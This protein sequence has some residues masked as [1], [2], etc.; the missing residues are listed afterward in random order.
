MAEERHNKIYKV[1]PGNFSIKMLYNMFIDFLQDGDDGW[2]LVRNEPW[3]YGAVLKVPNWKDGEYGYLGMMYGEIKGTG[4]NHSYSINSASS[5]GQWVTQVNTLRKQVAHPVMNLNLTDGYSFSKNRISQKNT[6][7]WKSTT[8]KRYDF[9]YGSGKLI[10]DLKAGDTFITITTESD[11]LDGI[12]YKGTYISIAGK[13]VVVTQNTSTYPYW[14]EVERKDENGDPILDDDG[15]PVIDTK[16]ENYIDI[17]FSP[18]FEKD[19]KKGTKV[20]LPASNKKNI[21]ISKEIQTS[22]PGYYYIRE[23]EHFYSDADVIWFNMFKQYESDFDWNELMENTRK[24][25]CAKRLGWSWYTS[26]YPSWS[27]EPPVYPGEGCPVI[28]SSPDKFG[29][30]PYKDESEEE[31]N[32][33]FREPDEASGF[34]YFDELPKDIPLMW[35]Y[36]FGPNDDISE[37][38]LYGIDIEFTIGE[39]TFE[40]CLEREYIKKIHIVDVEA[41]HWLELHTPTLV[42]RNNLYYEC[43][44][45]YGEH[46]ETMVQLL[47][48]YDK[49]HKLQHG[50]ESCYRAIQPFNGY[51]CHYSIYYY[52]TKTSCNYYVCDQNC[53]LPI[54][55]NKPKKLSSAV[56]DGELTLIRLADAKI[57]DISVF[58]AS[59]ING[60][61]YYTQNNTYYYFWDFKVY[62]TSGKT[63][64]EIVGNN[65]YLSPRVYAFKP[66]PFTPTGKLNIPDCVY[67]YM[68]KTKHNANLAVNYR[69]WWDMAQVGFFEPFAS[70]YEYQFPAMVMSSNIGVRPCS[71]LV[72]YNSNYPSCYEHMQFD[73]TQGNKSWGHA[74][75]G[76]SAT[77]WDGTQTFADNHACSQTQAMTPSGRWES[78]FNYGIRSKSYYSYYWGKFAHGFREPEYIDSKYFITTTMTP[79][80]EE[81][82]NVIPYGLESCNGYNFDISTLEYDIALQ[83]KQSCYLLPFYLGENT[84]HGYKQNMLGAVPSMYMVSRPVTR[85]GLYKNPTKE[86]DLFVIM[87]NC[88][89]GRPW[90]YQQDADYLYTGQNKSVEQQ[91][92]EYNKYRDLGQNMNVAMYIGKNT[93]FSTITEY[94][95]VAKTTD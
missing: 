69:D 34:C 14:Y 55:G 40:E 38:N 20:E 39:K 30:D 70:D 64:E 62:T 79:N 76:Q 37:D 65:S 78:F 26:T 53:T 22:N 59:T 25:P 43:N 73:Y 17:K 93:D 50:V 21:T 52:V 83:N 24:N 71:Q 54:S 67:I 7:T 91:A 58:S 66:V 3:P 86:D 31:Q 92:E 57:A 81:A 49:V 36:F 77:W 82:Y 88:W 5:Y 89:E 63:F 1:P 29:H 6:R 51:T 12:I 84:Q 48:N 56:N 9:T 4:K 44:T 46:S 94:T 95:P 13:Q 35:G 8:E 72:S 28:A 33:S 74:M 42:K 85:Y 23:A 11:L 80:V 18:A 87:P 45:D 19:L 75:I 60:L 41:E 61:Y 15:N 32:T 2:E 47:L 90:H 27:T 16:T 68:S 10:E